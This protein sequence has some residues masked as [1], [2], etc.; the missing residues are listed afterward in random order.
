[1][2]QKRNFSRLFQVVYL[3][4]A[5]GPFPDTRPHPSAPGPCSTCTLGPAVSEPALSQGSCRLWRAAPKLQKFS[6]PWKSE[7]PGLRQA[8]TY[9]HCTFRQGSSLQQ[10]QAAPASKGVRSRLALWEAARNPV[11]RA[12]ELGDKERRPRLLAHP[13]FMQIRKPKAHDLT[14]E[15]DARTKIWAGSSPNAVSDPI[16]S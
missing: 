15:L 11:P 2:I 12:Q 4:A 7:P 10:P 6:L 3:G 8:F 16:R 14:Q 13:L 9:T 1:M 5:S